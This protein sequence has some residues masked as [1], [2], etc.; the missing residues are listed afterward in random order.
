MTVIF[1]ILSILTVVCI[2]VIFWYVEV[3][4]VQGEDFS[5]LGL[6]Q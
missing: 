2:C 4:E 6:P 5:G 3:W 1:N